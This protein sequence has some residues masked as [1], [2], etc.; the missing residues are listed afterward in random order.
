MTLT[1]DNLEDLAEWEFESYQ[2]GDKLDYNI[3]WNSSSQKWKFQ[4][5]APISGRGKWKGAFFAKQDDSVDE[6]EWK[7]RTLIHS[8]IKEANP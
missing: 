8:Y 4:L 1:R 5:V 3:W 2:C 6:V 7:M